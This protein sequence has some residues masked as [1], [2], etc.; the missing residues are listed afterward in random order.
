[1]EQDQSKTEGGAAVRS[2]DGLGDFQPSIH[3][4]SPGSWEAATRLPVVGN[5]AITAR[6]WQEA[7]LKL[8]LVACAVELLSK[9]SAEDKAPSEWT[10]GEWRTVLK[11]MREAMSPNAEL[12]DRRENNP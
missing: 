2:S 1:M 11:T 5:V 12:S 10:D 4:N 7:R 6:S 8:W 9:Q 3:C